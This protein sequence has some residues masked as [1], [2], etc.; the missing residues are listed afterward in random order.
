MTRKQRLMAAIRG[1]A[2]D[3]PPV[4]FYELNGVDEIPDPRD[5]FNVFT[6]P[7]WADLIGL[8]RE[9]SDRIVM[10]GPKIL[11]S[12]NPLDELT[13]TEGW[14][15]E[16]S[17]SYFERKTITFQRHQW[18]QLTRRDRDINTVWT[19]EHFIKNRRDLDKWITL[20]RP[21]IGHQVDVGAVV[22]LET[23][24]GETGIVMLDS[25]D[26]LCSAAGLFEMGT[27]TILAYTEQALF[28]QLLE[29]FAESH[30][31]HVERAARALPGRLWRIYGP[32]YA[33]APYLPPRLFHDYVT[34]YDRPLIESIQAHGGYA[35]LHSHGN[36][37]GILPEM[38]ALGV[39]GLDPLEPPPQG[40]MTL[41]EIRR[42]VGDDLTLFGN[43]EISE[44]ETLSEERFRQRVDEALRDGPGANGSHFI[45]MPSACPLGR[46][47][48]EQ[49]LRNYQLM[50][51]MAKQK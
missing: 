17:G 40:D 16:S 10:R 37:R 3:R 20:P 31:E 47:I 24:L 5:P 51:E 48:S 18:T 39:D 11:D 9:Q 27:Y 13:S 49:T 46:E 29:W 32:E 42:V 6:G 2:V 36:L 33:S 44:I 41:S 15:D 4:C 45:L 26:P 12:S 14:I 30:V 35:R 34:V 43:I 23:E 1:E 25:G 21:V 22:D 50:I 8:V 28:H 7:R 38:I 19:L